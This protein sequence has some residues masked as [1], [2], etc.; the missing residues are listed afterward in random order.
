[1]IPCLGCHTVREMLEAFVDGELPVAEQVSVAMHLRGCATC[2]ARVEDM[3]LIGTA[4]RTGSPAVPGT[5]DDIFTLSV[6]QSE[7]LARISAEHDASFPVRLRG[8]FQDMRFLWPALGAT[9]ALV[10]ALF[11]TVTAYRSALN[12]DPES[13]ARMIQTLAS[14]RVALRPRPAPLSSYYPVRL[15]SLMLAPRPLS[16]GPTLEELPEDEAVFALSAVVTRE[17]RVAGY[18]LLQSVRAG[19]HR[20]AAAAGAD[21]EVEAMLDAVMDSRFEPAQN[22]DGGA[23]TVRVVWLLARTTVKARAENVGGEPITEELTQ[24]V[25]RLE[26]S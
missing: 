22:A 1:M 21:E 3:R 18:E 12:P 11:T 26:R 6:I 9:A 14:E 19:V 15:D 16:N 7:V 2:E 17:G 20:H 13:M 4:I 24:P 25:P 10:V 5:A 8:M 23:V